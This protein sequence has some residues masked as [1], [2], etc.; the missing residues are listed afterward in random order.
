MR[1]ARTQPI[2]D[3]NLLLSHI[4]WLPYHFI[5]ATR[6]QDLAFF[7]GFFDALL[8]ISKISESRRQAKKLFIITDAQVLNSNKK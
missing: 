8:Q 4:F 7:I 3:I 1:Q 6:R 2:T 5:S